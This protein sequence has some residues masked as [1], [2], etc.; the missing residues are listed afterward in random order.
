MSVG[1]PEA[2]RFAARERQLLTQA[3]P[4]V[5]LPAPKHHLKSPSPPPPQPMAAAPPD[6]KLPLQFQPSASRWAL[7]EGGE[8]GA[9]LTPSSSCHPPPH[10]NKHRTPRSVLQPLG[11]PWGCSRRGTT[12]NQSDLSLLTRNYWSRLEP[13]LSPS[14][15]SPPLTPEHWLHPVSQQVLDPRGCVPTRL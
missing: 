9:Q 3:L 1:L 4:T 11:S 10:S 5:S 2:T 7:G 15:L 12:N 8:E 6:W 13:P 14:L